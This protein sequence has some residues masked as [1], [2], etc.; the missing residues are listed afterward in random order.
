MTVLTILQWP[1]L[2]LSE[3]CS[4]IA[5]IDADIRR[6]SDDMLE[7]MYAAPGRGLAAP[8]VGVLKR[9]FV[10]DTDWKDA[11]ATPMVFVNPVIQDQS[12]EVSTQSEGC[13]SI[14]G[15]TASITR[16]ARITLSWSDLT[17]T[18]RRADFDGFA[19]A[20]IQH[21]ID[22]LNGVVTLDHLN[23]E[24]RAQTLTEY[25]GAST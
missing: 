9:I 8:Q 22:H 7:T 23:P 19:A 17:G 21:E 12:E 4:E 25:R 5:G 1:D 11:T 13:L 18:R 6:L 16:P 3:L 24:Q 14:P 10:M 15:V 20:C 2:R